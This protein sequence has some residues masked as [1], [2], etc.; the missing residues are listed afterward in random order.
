MVLGA[1]LRTVRLFLKYLANLTK[2]IKR[3]LKNCC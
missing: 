3:R 1:E 2:R